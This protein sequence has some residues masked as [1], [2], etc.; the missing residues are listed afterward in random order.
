VVTFPET[1]RVP[2][3]DRVSLQYQRKGSCEGCGK[4]TLRVKTF[5]APTYDEAVAKGEAWTEPLYHVK[6]Q[7]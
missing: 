4:A 7:P 1:P 3:V 2:R 5:S 6:C